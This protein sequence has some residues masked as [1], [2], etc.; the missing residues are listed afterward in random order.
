VDHRTAR[1]VEKVRRVLPRCVRLL[2]A[3][4]RYAPQREVD[5]RCRTS[6][7]A[8]VRPHMNAIDASAE[9]QRRLGL[10]ADVARDHVRALMVRPARFVL[11]GTGASFG[12]F[13]ILHEL[14]ILHGDLAGRYS[15]PDGET[16]RRAGAFLRSGSHGGVSSPS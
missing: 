11:P 16:F 15:V 10:R 8:V 2:D 5:A 9:A 6:S 14:G 7:P 13:E 1:Y 3:H 12:I 4:S